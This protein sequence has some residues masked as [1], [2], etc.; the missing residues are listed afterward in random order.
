M[1]GFWRDHFQ[2]FRFK[3]IDS[4]VDSVRKYLS[5]TG[6]FEETRYLSGFRC[7]N[8]S[9]INRALNPCQDD[10]AVGFFLI[11]K[12]RAITLGQNLKLVDKDLP[13]LQT[14]LQKLKILADLILAQSLCW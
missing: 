11:M 1:V 13:E 5:P 10:S 9:K 4:G 14:N 8:Y 2:Y 6:L 7:N 12:I 3:D